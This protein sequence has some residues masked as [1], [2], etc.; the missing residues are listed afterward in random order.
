MKIKVALAQMSSRLGAVKDNLKKHVYYL[1]RAKEE[2]VNIVAFPELSLTGYLLKDLAYELSSECRVALK[3]L[4][5]MS[6]GI[7]SI[8]GLVDESRTG[9]YRN[10]AAMVKD[11]TVLGIQPK[12]YLPCYGLFEEKRYFKE[13]GAEDLKVFDTDFCKVGIIICEDLWHP[14][15]CELLARKGADVIFCIAASPIRGFYG[16]GGVTPVENAYDKLVGARAIENTV[17]LIFVNKAGAEDEEY[18]WG[19][20]MVVAPDGRVIKRAKTLEEDFMVVEIDLFDVARVR[21]FSSFRD[22]N[23][24]LHRVL[25]GL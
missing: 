9:I 1:E 2:D 4:A 22:H 19:G 20:S 8:V 17:F 7:Y 25:A 3:D 18:F 11:G 16:S 21:R 23:R 24:D 14:E 6:Y 15:P 13:G 12:S 10:A 5:E